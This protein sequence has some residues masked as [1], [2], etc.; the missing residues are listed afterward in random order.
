MITELQI[1]DSRL[2]PIA[3]KVLAGERLNAGDGLA[4]FQSHRSAGRRLAGQPRAGKAPREKSATSTSIGTSIPPTSVWR[5]ASFAR[6]GVRRIRRAPTRSRWMKSVAR[7][8]QG[9]AEGATEFHIV[10]GLHPDLPF[11][12][13]LDLIRGLKRPLPAGALE[14][15]HHGGGAL[16]RAHLQAFHSRHAAEDEG[17]GSRIRCPAAA[18][19]FFIRACGA[20]S[21]TTR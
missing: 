9:V 15:L 19:R 7:A 12:Y 14:G 13:Y 4:L 21:A 16:L 6:L 8:A 3:Q 10:G 17:S 1:T 2:E 5:T 11:D 18:R 20:S